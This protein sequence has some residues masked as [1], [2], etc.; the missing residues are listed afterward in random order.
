MKGKS[1]LVAAA[2]LMSAASTA[3][4]AE[5]WQY[6]RVSPNPQDVVTSAADFETV[7]VIYPSDWAVSVKDGAVATLVNDETQE[8]V[9]STSME[10]WD[11]ALQL[12]GKYYVQMTFEAPTS[13]GNYTLT[14]PAGALLHEGQGNPQAIVL[15]YTLNDPTLSTEVV[16]DLQLLSA[17]PEAGTAMASVGLP[18]EGRTY[19]FNTNINKYVAYAT[20][21]W[22]DVT[23][24]ENAEWMCYTD[25]NHELGS[26]APIEI[27]KVGDVPAMYKNHKYEMRVT[28]Y[29]SYQQPRKELGSFTVSYTGTAEEYVYSTVK[30]ISVDP[31][32]DTFV[33]ES[34]EEGH[35]TV[36]FDAPV[37]IDRT[38]SCVSLG[39]MGSAP[40]ENIESNATK[41]EWTFTIPA[42]QL[43]SNTV[44]CFVVAKDA[45]GRTVRGNE[46]MQKYESGDND[47]AGFMF[48]YGVQI[49]G[50]ELIVTPASGTVTSLKTFTVKA[51]TDK[52][53][54]MLPSWLEYPYLMK[55]RDIVYKFNFEDDSDYMTSEDYGTIKL[56]LPEEQVEPGTYILIIPY[57]TLICTTQD[58]QGTG[59]SNAAMSIVYTIEGEAPEAVYDIEPAAIDPAAGQVKEL[60]K[61]KISFDED[62]ALVNY[63]AYILDADGKELQKAEIAY[64]ED[65]SNMRDFHIT[66]ATPVTEAGT[67]TLY[68]P[69]GTFGTEEYAQSSEESR[70]GHGS[71]EIRTEYT[72]KDSGVAGIAAD[73]ERGDVYNAAG[74]LVL[75]D[76]TAADVAKLARGLYIFN[77]KKV[78]VK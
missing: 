57:G 40:Y 66:L 19:T 4:A 8:V 75:R 52:Y 60:S 1:L 48:S 74:V 72:I 22:Y 15:K 32:P 5:D 69:Q 28:C 10:I 20:A 21:D 36:S 56:T 26:D 50:A 30:A 13:N 76:A 61:F 53:N 14:V 59:D 39:Q 41:T 45:D 17:S 68:I 67:Y 49:G 6:E 3:V 46:D 44:S 37:E 64:D 54:D 43:E 11:F 23:D 55:G 24:P 27:I 34:V 65:F 9:N 38:L 47:E 16:P 33:I 63:D 51:P 35:V 7:N 31:N 29:N 73:N 70:T 78:M 12:E 77:G 62:L 58:A 71:K 18:G 42:S 25:R 2:I